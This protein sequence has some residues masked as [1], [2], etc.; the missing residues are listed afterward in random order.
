MKRK[1]KQST[2]S[3]CI[4]ALNSEFTTQR[5]GDV[6]FNNGDRLFA[7]DIS[8]RAGISTNKKEDESAFYLKTRKVWR[9]KLIGIA[10]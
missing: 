7:K 5:N 10:S 6:V 2:S 3:T 9:D 8:L 1:I 4:I